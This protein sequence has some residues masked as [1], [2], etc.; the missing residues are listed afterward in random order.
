MRERLPDWLPELRMF[1]R[2]EPVIVRDDNNTVVVARYL[3]DVDYRR[4]N[5]PGWK[6]IVIRPTPGAG[7]RASLGLDVMAAL[8]KN[9]DLLRQDKLGPDTWDLAAA[10]LIE[11]AVTDVF[12]VRAHTL[13]IERI[14]ELL[15]LNIA[16]KLPSG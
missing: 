10:W 5:R 9:P 8:G 16:L 12:L 6:R 4:R 7:D 15:D 2:P 14:Q 3:A 13:P 1:P 11:A